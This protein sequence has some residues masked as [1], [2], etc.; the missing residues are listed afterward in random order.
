MCY[1]NLF[2]S[3]NNLTLVQLNLLINHIET[4]FSLTNLD[5]N[6]LENNNN[7]DNNLDFTNLDK[8]IEISIES[9]LPD[10]NISL[11]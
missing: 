3:I 8:E 5:T 4:Y 6:T 11:L 10:K 7:K 9:V 1:I 2:N